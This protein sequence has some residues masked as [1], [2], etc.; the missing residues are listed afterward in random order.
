MPLE[1]F[2]IIE[3]NSKQNYSFLKCSSQNIW[4]MNEFI[5]KGSTYFLN[6]V[7]VTLLFEI[8][9]PEN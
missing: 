8:L 2:Y 4:N 9:R 6:E 3:I 5:A 7:M 1:L